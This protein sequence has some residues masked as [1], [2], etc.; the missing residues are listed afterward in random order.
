MISL[1]FGYRGDN[2][3]RSLRKETLNPEFY[4]AMEFQVRG[5]PLF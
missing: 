4:T 3:I 2:F 1:A 5:S